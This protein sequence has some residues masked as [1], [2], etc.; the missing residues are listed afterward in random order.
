MNSEFNKDPLFIDWYSKRKTTEEETLLFK[1]INELRVTTTKQKPI[2]THRVVSSIHTKT[3]NFNAEEFLN[4]MHLINISE[5]DKDGKQFLSVTTESGET[6]EG[7]IDN[8]KIVNNLLDDLDLYD[9]C[10]KYLTFIINIYNEWIQIK[11]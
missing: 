10:D 5:P 11:N 1:R 2:E 9:L 6:F 7:E 3:D 8:Y 4:K